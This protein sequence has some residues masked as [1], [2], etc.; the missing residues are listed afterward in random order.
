MA[1]AIGKAGQFTPM[2]TEFIQILHTGGFHWVCVYNIGCK[3]GATVKLYNSLYG[4]VTPHTKKQIAILLH[5]TVSNTIEIRVQSVQSQP[6]GVDCGIFAL[7]FATALCY[8]KDPC[9]VFFNR[10][11]M[12]Q[13]VWFCIE[14]NTLSM[15]PHTRRASSPELLACVKVPVYCSCHSS[16]TKGKMVQCDDGAV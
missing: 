8:G 2:Q 1:T 15:F 10:R 14:S 3:D 9:E 11:A 12:R 7:A 6:N 4:C 13:H 16:S 5:C